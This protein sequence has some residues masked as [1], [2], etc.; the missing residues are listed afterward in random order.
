MLFIFHEVNL[1]SFQCVSC[2]QLRSVIVF[3]G[4][5]GYSNIFNREMRYNAY[6]SF[7]M[8][9]LIMYYLSDDSES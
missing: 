7:F 5:S 1:Q 3:Q 8:L 4:K 9:N 2:K 6:S